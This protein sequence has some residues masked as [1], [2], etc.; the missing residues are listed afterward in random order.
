MNLAFLDDVIGGAGRDAPWHQ[1][2]SEGRLFP[3]CTIWSWQ[4][5]YH[6]A[7]CVLSDPSRR[8]D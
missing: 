3:A 6:K 7:V 4:G 8:E 5:I 2:L 1:F